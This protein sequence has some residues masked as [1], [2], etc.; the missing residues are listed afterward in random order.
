MVSFYSRALERSS[1]LNEGPCWDSFFYKGAVLYW[2]P[3]RDPNLEN[4]DVSYQVLMG[5][6]QG[7]VRFLCPYRV[8]EVFCIGFF[9]WFR[10]ATR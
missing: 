6:S 7:S 2:D 9:L 4:P 8:L 3:Q 5:F 10:G 1:S